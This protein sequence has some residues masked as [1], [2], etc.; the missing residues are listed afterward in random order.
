MT[1]DVSGALTAYKRAQEI[2]AKVASERAKE[3]RPDAVQ[4][5]LN[6]AGEKGL[7]LTDEYF[8]AL[9]TNLRSDLMYATVMNNIGDCYLELGR[10]ADARNAFLESIE[11]IPDGSS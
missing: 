1:G 5:R 6:D 2:L 9:K 10:M 4:T 8:L 7:V 3:E 11:F